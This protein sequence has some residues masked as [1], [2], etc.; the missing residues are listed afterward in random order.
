MMKT[1][2]TVTLRDENLMNSFRKRVLIESVVEKTAT[3]L[4][5]EELEY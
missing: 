3:T 4:K 5:V 2:I 1:E